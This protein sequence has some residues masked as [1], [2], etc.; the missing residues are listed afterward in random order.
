MT[1]DTMPQR[2]KTGRGKNRRKGPSS[3][4]PQVRVSTAAPVDRTLKDDHTLSADPVQPP[5]QSASPQ[6]AP[7]ASGPTAVDW[8]DSVPVG[9]FLLD[10]KGLILRVNPAG[11]SLVGS[12]DTSLLARPFVLCIDEADRDAFRRRYAKALKAATCIRGDF[13]MVRD[14]DGGPLFAELAMDPVL[15]DGPA[16]TCLVTAV[17][18]TRHKQAEEA[19]RIE[20]LRLKSTLDAMPDLIYIVDPQGDIEY[21]NP[22][23]ARQ[24]GPWEGKKCYQYLGGTHQPCFGCRFGEILA[25]NILHTEWVNETNGRIYDCTD[26]PLASPDGT[27][28]KIK[29]M[30]DVTEHR[31]AE[32]ALRQEQQEI[33]LANRILEVFVEETGNTLY[34]KVL[35]LMLDAMHSAHGVFGYV[36]EEGTLVCPTMSRLF[37]AC[38][39][40]DKCIR[41][42]SDK[43]RGLWSRA[44]REKRIL[45]TNDPPPVPAGHVPIQNNLAAPIL[46]EGRPIGL[47]NLANKPGGYTEQDVQFVGAICNRV[48]PVLY[49]W[50]QRELREQERAEAARELRVANERLTLAQRSAGA[51]V[52]DWDIVTDTLEWSGEFRELLGLP[53]SAEATFDTWRR[54][55]HPDDRDAA[56]QRIEEAVRNHTSLVNEYRVLLP[57]GQVR[58]ISAL[59]NTLYDDQGRAVRMSGICLD[60]TDRKRIEEALRHSE[61]R[62]KRAQEI[63]HLG[64]WELNLARNELTWS[65]EV[66]RLFGLEP[67]EFE[68]TYEAFLEHVHPDD[69]HAV[70]V[71]YRDSIRTGKDSYEI[72]HR[73]VRAHTG[74]VRWVEERCQ[75]VRDAEGRIAR[76][77]GMVLDITERKHAEEQIR[78]L[79]R[80]PSENPFPVLR[81]SSD[82]IVQHSNDP[83]RAVLDEW[84]CDVHETIP[85]EWRAL[86]REALESRRRIIR[87][88]R[89]GERTI[90]LAISPVVEGGYVNLYGR[91]VTEQRQAEQALQESHA[92]LEVLVEKRTQELAQTVVALQQE[93]RHRALAEQRLQE[94]SRVLDAFFTYSITPLVILDTDFNF[95]R[96]N[97][98][99]A[100]ACGRDLSEFAGHN[101]FELYP[102]EENQRIFEEVVRSKTPYQATAKPF[103]YPDHPEWGVTYW[104]WILFPLLDDAGEVEFLV[105]S[106]EDVTRETRAAL[107]LAESEQRF[108]L[109]AESIDDVFWISTPGIG[110]MLYVSPAYE[111]IW[112]RSRESLY[113]DP[114]SFLGAVHPDDRERLMDGLRA[115][116]E[117]YW[118]FE[119]RIVRPDGSCRWIRDR[120]FPLLDEQGDLTMMCGVATDVTAQKQV[121]SRLRANQ[122]ALRSLTAELQLS[123]ER[124][125]RRIARDLHDS[126]GQILAFASR[127]LGILHHAAPQAMAERLAA[128]RD[129]LDRAIQETRTLSFSLSP[130]VLYDLGLGAAIEDLCERLLPD[131]GVRYQCEV[132]CGPHVLDEATQALLY[133]SVRELLINVCKHAGAKHVRIS[134][135]NVD[136]TLRIVVRDDGAGFDMSRL[137]WQTGQPMGFGLLSIRERLRH[138]GGRFQMQSTEGQGTTVTLIVPLKTGEI[139]EGSHS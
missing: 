95:V 108:R 18:I 136:H 57:T 27:V 22:A 80:F 86:C 124:E 35:D 69:R 20:Q 41:Y 76:S 112:G 12:K 21:V 73:I 42:T 130:A 52:W 126:V 6:A 61:H 63:A 139:L 79:A 46:F 105:F 37:D 24:W 38:E 138:M 129:H 25:G 32:K 54:V 103:S 91:D 68:A 116:A 93:N 39:M 40:R 60:I 88:I 133:R 137:S 5:R 7:G 53:S 11:A 109:L 89:C 43:W 100:K 28:S 92:R 49:A 14:A 55:L 127:E 115:H 87:D 118:D 51:G 4:T 48:A 107:A 125:R 59:G 119:Y 102:H 29:V 114:R 17:D 135:M 19:V 26:A 58:W 2:G 117:G 1:D 98:A 8:F 111:T 64:S 121:E 81:V 134:T 131:H 67:R 45:F 84:G 31:R 10:A 15:A 99:Y 50:I 132:D 82:G 77:V 62:L 3:K 65:D 128:V 36:D 71:A 122:R 23:M 75:H 16:D 9:C 56:Q 106:L 97:Q 70:N 44:M 34:D 74:E 13:R 123:E 78:S 110:Q 94:R 101:H 120:G 85:A 66:Y 113:D 96:V 83:G 90:S 30:R 104:N 72:E 33:A 47:F